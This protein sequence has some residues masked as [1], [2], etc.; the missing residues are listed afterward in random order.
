MKKI[1]MSEY[2]PKKTYPKDTVFVLDDAP[3]NI[4]LPEFLK[5]RE[6]REDEGGMDATSQ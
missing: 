5:N 4:P 1:S 3:P 2:D 6:K